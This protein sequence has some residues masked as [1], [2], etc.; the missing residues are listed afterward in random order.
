MRTPDDITERL[1]A[2][3]RGDVPVPEFER[4]VYAEPRLESE[5]GQALFLM[6]ISTHFTDRAEV[7]SLRC[8]LAAHAR[9]RPSPDCCCIRLRTLDVV[10]MG[11][12]QAPAPAFEAG[13]E[14]SDGDVFRSLEQVAQR[15]D[16]YWWLWAARCR[17]CGQG[18]L[19]GQ[20]ERQNDVFCM[21]RL[22]ARQLQDIVAQQQW[23]SDFDAYETL[24]RIG[25]DRGRRVRFAEPMTSS[26]NATIADLARARPGIAISE[27]ARLLNLD[28]ATATELARKAIGRD[29]VRI[30]FD[31][32]A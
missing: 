6:A 13:R 1:W 18:W 24:L 27:V 23:P 9:G 25:F 31:S 14:W 15:G 8:A 20:E 17:L 2:F 12:F 21:L 10:D 32:E 28:L 26:M 7:W 30:T 3:V 22:D 11:H 19:I 5:L 29:G 4:W 16:P